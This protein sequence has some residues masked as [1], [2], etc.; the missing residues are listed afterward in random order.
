[1]DILYYKSKL[2]Y[3]I[4]GWNYS[5]QYE[6]YLQ[7]NGNTLTLQQ[8]WKKQ[9][10]KCVYVVVIFFP[11]VIFDFLLLLWMFSFVFTH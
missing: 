7:E 5:L 2:T 10:R 8:I 6:T 1:M 4:Y 11:Q 3:D 9:K